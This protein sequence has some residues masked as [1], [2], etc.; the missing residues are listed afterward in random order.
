MNIIQHVIYELSFIWGKMNIIAEDSL[1]NSSEELLQR[2]KG[3]GQHIC[4]F[5]EEGYIQSSTH[6][7]KKI[8]ASHKE[9]MPLS[10]I[11]VFFWYDKMQSTGLIKSSPENV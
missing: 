1:W 6:F 2:G 5:G 10:T 11:L 9:Q 4:D 7:W 3:G 8:A